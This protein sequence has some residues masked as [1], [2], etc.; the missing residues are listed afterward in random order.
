MHHL[1]NLVAHLKNTLIL[2]DGE[3][4]EQ[5]IVRHIA[6]ARKLSQIEIAE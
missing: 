4:W 6:F 3:I 5:S 2:L 1:M